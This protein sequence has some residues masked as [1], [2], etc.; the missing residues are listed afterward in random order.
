[1]TAPVKSA[2][3][4]SNPKKDRRPKPA[5]APKRVRS[6]PRTTARLAAVQALYEIELS[7]SDAH[8]VVPDMI[9]RGFANLLEDSKI[10]TARPDAAFFETLVLGTS[11]ERST[12][13]DMIRST[14]DQD[15]HFERLELIIR[16]ILRLGAYELLTQSDV[17]ARVVIA[18]YMDLADAF[19]GG[20]EPALVNGVLDKIAHTVREDEF[21][22]GK[23]E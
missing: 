19:F 6:A 11:G 18:E 20:R 2:D 21:T 22:G 17:P 3:T 15:G 9:G 13:D 10:E 4:S 1:M 23:A 7:S 8:E 5:A 16:G 12:L 14:L